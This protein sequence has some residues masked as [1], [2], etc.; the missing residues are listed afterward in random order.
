MSF[1]F[2]FFFKKMNFN[3]SH[4]Y[5]QYCQFTF[6]KKISEKPN[7]ND[8]EIHYSKYELNVQC[9]MSFIIACQSNGRCE[10]NRQHE[11]SERNRK[12]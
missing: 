10:L 5:L 6:E 7:I 2:C 1:F 3:F 11:I 9:E 12:K 4:E 8:Q